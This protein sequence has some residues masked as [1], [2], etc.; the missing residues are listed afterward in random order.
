MKQL[1]LAFSLFLSLNSFAQNLN[2][3]DYFELHVKYIEYKGEMHK[4]YRPNCLENKKDNF[5]KFLKKHHNR[6]DYI[7]NKNLKII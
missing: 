6:F 4:S 1:L 5:G 2:Y 7:L 3:C